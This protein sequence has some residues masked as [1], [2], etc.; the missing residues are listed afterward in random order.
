MVILSKQALKNLY[1]VLCD[2]Y[3]MHI[4]GIYSQV[5]GVQMK[6]FK[7]LLH[8]NFLALQNMHHPIWIHTVGLLDEAEKVLLVHAGGSMDV[9]IN[10]HQ[11][12]QINVK[13]CGNL[14]SLIV[15]Y[16]SINDIWLFWVIPFYSCK[17]LCGDF[18]SALSFPPSRLTSHVHWIL[19]WGTSD[20]DEC[21]TF[22]G[23]NHKDPLAFT[24]QTHHSYSL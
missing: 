16:F 7:K 13:I 1:D 8:G 6:R 4:Q 21:M 22:W 23:K 24:K 12:E 5:I 15:N 2:T 19:T 20:D 17:S 3:S 11:R 14:I 9:S 18:S 10:L